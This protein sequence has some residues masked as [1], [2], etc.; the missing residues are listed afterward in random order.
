M[1][2]VEIKFS[3]EATFRQLPA[4]INP[5]SQSNVLSKDVP[6][7]HTIFQC[8]AQI[9]TVEKWG[10]NEEA[11]IVIRKNYQEK[12]LNENFLVVDFSPSS[13]I[14]FTLPLHISTYFFEAFPIS[15]KYLVVT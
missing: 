2:V 3:V 8:N 13:R 4:K 6:L 15:A 9:L 7:A 12:Y 5:S 1:V 10:Q 11:S 14:S